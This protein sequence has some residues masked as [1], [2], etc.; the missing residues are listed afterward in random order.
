MPEP[1]L[2]GGS[3]QEQ[4]LR[5]EALRLNKII[6]ALM[7]RAERSTSVQ[8]SDFCLFQ[9][10][11]MLE[12]QVRSRTADLEQSLRENETINRALCE[13][14]ARF[15]VMA[16]GCPALMWVNDVTGDVQFVNRAYR[17]FFDTTSEQVQG[18][19]WQL[20]IHPNDAPEYCEAFECAVREQAPFKGEARVRR[21]DGEWRW[22]TSSGEPRFSSSG[23]FLGHVGLSS[24]ITESKQ[25]ARAREFQHSLI[26][27]IQELSPDGILVVNHE[28]RVVSHNQKSLDIWRIPLAT[29]PDNL[30]DHPSGDGPHLILS[31]ALE[32]VKDPEALLSRVQEL[33]A[34]PDENDHCEMELKDGRILERHSSSV[35]SATGQYLGRVWFFR[36]ITERKQA[37]QAL[38]TSEE[39]FRQL[40]ENIREVFWMM[41]P[42]AD[43]ILYVSPAYEQVWG[44]TC[45]SV[46]QNPLSWTEAIHPDDREQAHLLFAKRK[47]GEPLDSVYR[48][49]TPDGQEKWIRDRAFPIRDQAGQL[50]RVVGIAEEITE[51]KRHE[52]ELIHARQGAEAANR[53]KS[54]FL[55]NMSHEIR[56][57]MNAIMGMTTLILDQELPATTL[58]YVNIIRTSS[59]ALLTVINDILD[60]SKIESGKLDLERE[61]LSLLDCVEEVLELLGAKAAEKAIEIG[62][63]LGA[64]VNEWVY[65]D[66]TRLRQILL[67]LV[68]NAI[69]FT[70]DGEVVVSVDLR[71]TDSGTNLLHFAIRDTGIGIPAQKVDKLFQSFTQVDASTTRRFGGTGL[72]LAISKRLTELMGGRIWVTS[73]LGVGSVFQF[74]IPCE[75]APAQK[76]HFVPAED[77][78][79]KLILIVDDNS[80]TRRILS[81]YAE[82]WGL[83]CCT[84]N[85]GKEALEALRV[86]SC[87]AMLLDCQ[88][89]GINGMQL[90]C[91]IKQEFNDAAPPMIMLSC[92]APPS[93]KALGDAKNPFTAILS[94]PIRREHLHRVLAQVLSG[95]VRKL[96]PSAGKLFDDGFA[97][98]FPLRILL[99]ED[100]PVNQKLAVRMLQKLG[101]L[102]DA[103]GN[104]LEV[105][106]ALNRQD[107][108]LVLMDVQMPEMD[109][110]EATRLIIS[111]WGSSRPWITALTA[112][113]MK[114]NR[115]E[116]LAAGVDDF[117]S[118]PMSIQKLKEALQ[119]SHQSV[120]NL[121]NQWLSPE[122]RPTEGLIQDIEPDAVLIP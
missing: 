112:G 85:S 8:E 27:A 16:D 42:A 103:V 56:T 79:G 115:D 41:T 15:R 9:T 13:S 91:T 40:A 11:V 39:K 62:V 78:A 23:E 38:Q 68:G 102:A 5:D 64:Q 81:A 25:A 45:E 98:R 59:D 52:E 63:V 122:K 87:D 86:R 71:E 73:Q 18:S 72:G 12:E 116:C 48:I 75:P 104:G 66:V 83:S 82:S 100:N 121:D 70:S 22:L 65:G 80:T 92:G 7:D 19:K 47:Q 44:R 26:R 90:A 43:E 29:I 1:T 32:R 110:L 113:A 94:K 95:V 14:E 111:S 97:Q 33:Y 30:P 10:A 49:R 17:E 105:I 69:K 84:A 31:A 3:S 55:A 35:W 77:W 57:P 96:E 101:Y 108:D 61:P 109:G 28:N 67:N 74:E 58:E 21:A 37:E 24:D 89:P 2:P 4:I 20:L 53:A 54:D 114:E 99:A 117:L 6:R 106:E 60:F 36:D 88:M 46:Y 119:R 118:K 51:R 76:R 34:H 107:Y 50:I 120:R 93:K